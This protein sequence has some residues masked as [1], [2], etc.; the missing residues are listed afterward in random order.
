MNKWSAIVVCAVAVALL[1]WL[2]LPQKSLP[3]QSAEVF[4][5]L[6]DL[7]L[8]EAEILE[9]QRSGQPLYRLTIKS[10]RQNTT[11]GTA[12]LDEPQL[13]YFTV[14]TSVWKVS[15]RS[16]TIHF[17]SSS[18]AEAN[19]FVRLKD[20]VVVEFLREGK[21][22]LYVLT[23]ALDLYPEQALAR[24]PVPVTILA[25]TSELQ[26]PSLEIDLATNSFLFEGDSENQV[27]AT[28]NRQKTD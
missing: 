17:G 11:R 23:E 21:T 13:D 3:G 26:A 9:F 14:D 20:S 7:I 18:N 19:E 28:L 4:P 8:D 12:V 5:D 2:L 1:F 10:A 25:A 15:S 6:P 22:P 27:H 16:G 24:S